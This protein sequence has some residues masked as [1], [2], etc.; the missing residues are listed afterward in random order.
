M[1]TQ[2]KK[3]I[4]DIY[5]LFH[6]LV[7]II[8]YYLKHHLKKIFYYIRLKNMVRSSINPQNIFY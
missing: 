3:T 2:L 5:L 4:N 6:Y 1:D 8:K 7:H